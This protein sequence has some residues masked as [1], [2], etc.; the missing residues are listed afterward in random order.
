MPTTHGGRS[1]ALTR[2]G[3][4]RLQKLHPVMRQRADAYLDGRVHHPLRRQARE[5]KSSITTALAI[6]ANTFYV[7]SVL[8]WILAAMRTTR[9]IPA[10]DAER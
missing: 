6:K 4:D 9:A 7:I 2:D 10:R 1:L 5:I 8:F 3:A